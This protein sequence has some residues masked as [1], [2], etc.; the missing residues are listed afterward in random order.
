MTSR[1][2]RQSSRGRADPVALFF[3]PTGSG[4]FALLGVDARPMDSADVLEVLH[5]RLDQLAGHP[6]SATPAAEEV[7]LALHS[8]A[9]Q[10]CDPALQ[11]LLLQQW[12]GSKE[13]PRERSGPGTPQALFERELH[14]AVGM[15]G[16]WNDQARLR[17]LAACEAR[18]VA[19]ADAVSLLSLR[20]PPVE[21]VRIQPRARS[22][23][24]YPALA[25]EVHLEEAYPQELHPEKE[26]VRWDIFLLAGFGALALVSVIATIILLSPSRPTPSPAPA[27]PAP[28]LG[29]ASPVPVSVQELPAI[30]A[31]LSSGDARAISLE[32]VGS[33]RDLATDG[34]AALQRFSRGYEA[35]GKSWT[36]MQADELAA[37]VSG[38]VDFAFAASRQDIDVAKAITAPLAT[39]I[40]DAKGSVRTLA[41]SAGIASRLLSE[42]DLGRAA[43]QSIA[44]LAIIPGAAQALDG[45]AS[46][47]AGIER[48]LPDIAV[49][50]AGSSNRSPQPWKEFIEVR[51]AVFADRTEPKDRLTIGALDALLHAPDAGVAGAPG[52]QVLAAALSWQASDDLR[53]AV[54]GWFD[55]MA[56]PG[57][58]ISAIT[59]AMVASS[60]PGIDS[61]MV[62][63][64]ASGPEARAAVRERLA[65]VWQA[66]PVR[67]SDIS[68]EWKALAAKLL[69]E[70]AT[71]P[72]AQLLL[73]SRLALLTLA[74]EDIRTSKPDDAKAA[75]RELVTPAASNAQTPPP[76]ARVPSPGPQSGAIDFAQAG[77]SVQARLEAL[78]KIQNS[79]LETD[80]LLARML[81]VESAR[82]SP[83]PVRDAARAELRRRIDAPAI[84]LATIEF[85]RQLPETPENAD[86]VSEVAGKPGAWK[87]RPKWKVSGLL[88]LLD[89]ACER[90]P[91]SSSEASIDAA[92][93]ALGRA[94]WLRAGES[95][96]PGSADQSIRRLESALD[97]TTRAVSR[98]EPGWSPSE[99]RRRK[100]A[101]LSIATA[102]LEKAVVMQAACV[103]WTALQAMMDRPR[104][105]EAIRDITREWSMRCRTAD[106][107]VLQL[108][109]GERAMLQLQVLR[110]SAGGKS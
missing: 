32:I 38:I 88:A 69:S 72:K 42:A 109:E 99:I 33:T 73:A 25:A 37:V 83:A 61:T 62:L 54:F 4:P 107:A 20:S 9:A 46:F 26:Y 81:V 47:R 50:I 102:S 53:N 93:D 35:F 66:G 55:D 10:L 67:T 110:L 94:W 13:R 65:Q 6:Q 14:L 31:D 57:E 24:T 23:S 58:A 12:G 91:A 18:G 34:A 41:M 39:P 5:R 30:P 97:S 36:M 90:F 27:T 51:D 44:S 76:P 22:R 8:A 60:A 84:L 49:A 21:P 108:L 7:R 87:N 105:G 11:E 43:I 3:G 70:P 74:G 101:R 79:S 48:A 40:G 2:V 68:E 85:F 28:E 86:W 78:K 89:R 77:N 95:G 63:A 103:E 59:R 56:I 71:D 29:V 80:S 1:G 104:A 96:E 19:V 106:T 15:S 64:P 52:V 16:G 92:A 98:R 45:A 82:G 17:V 100:E 75:L